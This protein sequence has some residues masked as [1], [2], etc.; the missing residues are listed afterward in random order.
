MGARSKARKR[1]LDIL[2]ESELRGVPARETLATRQAAV[3]APLHPYTVDLV[4]GVEDHR[5]EIDEAIAAYSTG[6][7]LERMPAVDRNLARLGVYELRYAD[8]VPDAVALSEA[9]TMARELST[10]ESPAFLNGLLGAIAA[11]GVA[12]DAET[13]ARG[14]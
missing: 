14:Q 5:A 12:D 10:E 4:E 6:W 9:V 2:F 13:A 11:S 7:S 3:D 8:D 1:A